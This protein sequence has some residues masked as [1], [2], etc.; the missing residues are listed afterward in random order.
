MTS[1]RPFL[2]CVADDITGLGMYLRQIQRRNKDGSVVR[3]VQLAHSVWDG[4]RAQATAQVVHSFGRADQV[5]VE[6]LRRLADSITRFTDPG[7]AAAQPAGEGLLG[8][9][10][11][12]PMGGAWVL[13]GL[14]SRL[15]FSGASN[16]SFGMPGRHAINAA[17][18]SMA[19]TAGM[20]SA[21]MG[22]H[23]PEIVES[24][25]ATALLLGND[26]WGASWIRSHR[27][28]QAVGT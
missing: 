9:T 3:Y 7:S 26:E 4:D 14:W 1:R 18:L 23:P 21:N 20:T 28:R 25:R 22:A 2:G 19:M 11:S 12:V 15:G 13:E 27:A 17:W 6:A 24:V 16:V 10:G 8:F 5:D